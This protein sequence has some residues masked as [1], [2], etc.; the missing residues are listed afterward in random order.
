[1]IRRPDTREPSRRH[2]SDKTATVGPL[3]ERSKWRIPEGCATS[4]HPGL[5]AHIEA[6]RRSLDR[7][8]ARKSLHG[9]PEGGRTCAILRFPDARRGKRRGIVAV[10]LEG[11]DA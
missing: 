8:H 7:S 10:F 4:T 9:R 2:R 11:S 3:A 5:A 6:A 1:A